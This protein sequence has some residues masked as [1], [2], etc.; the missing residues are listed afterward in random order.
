MTIN[1]TSGGLAASGLGDGAVITG[2]VL[3]LTGIPL[4]FFCFFGVVPI[5]VGLILLVMG[6]SATTAGTM[7]GT[8]GL[9]TAAQASDIQ[10][11]S[12]Q[13]P[14]QCPMC[15]NTGLIP[16]MSAMGQKTI[17]DNPQLA[18]M[19]VSESAQGDSIPPSCATDRR[20]R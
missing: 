12:A 16:A 11:A 7:V 13:A 10:R 5:I 4:L 6:L 9:S 18:A 15:R 20:A 19:A 8:A 17:Q 3:I 14:R 1:R 2:I